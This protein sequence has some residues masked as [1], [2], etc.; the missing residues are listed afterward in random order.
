MENTEKLV[1]DVC[2]WPKPA[3]VSGG[4]GG[5]LIPSSHVAWEDELLQPARA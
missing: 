4:T 2:S 5:S 3:V 1:T